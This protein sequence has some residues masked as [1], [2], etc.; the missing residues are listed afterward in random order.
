MD[1]RKLKAA[2]RQAAKTYAENCRRAHQIP[3]EVA[4]LG[5][6]A[7]NAGLSD[8]VASIRL[9]ERN[10]PKTRFSRQE[11][12]ASALGPTLSA[13]PDDE[14]ATLVE[15]VRRELAT[16][17]RFARTSDARYDINRHAALAR[18]HR[19]LIGGRTGERRPGA[20]EHNKRRPAEAER[21]SSIGQKLPN[22]MV[23]C[24]Q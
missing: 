21:L 3:L 7:M 14:R 2:L 13:I 12:D 24:S 10:M 22:Q 18:L 5:F 16:M 8:V 9:N 1:E 4:E 11:C 23:S 17:K 15:R 20:R 6:I 19:L